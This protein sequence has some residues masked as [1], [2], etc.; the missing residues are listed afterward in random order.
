MIHVFTKG[1]LKPGDHVVVMWPS[2]QSFLTLSEH[3]GCK[4]TRWNLRVNRDSDSSSPVW[5]ADIDE[6]ETLIAKEGGARALYINAPHSPTGFQFTEQEYRRIVDI[7]K[8]HDTYLVSDECYS[9][10]EWGERG[11]LPPVCEIYDKGISLD[12]VSKALGLVSVNID[13]NPLEITV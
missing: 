2:Y 6:L 4:V 1:F 10:L 5:E 13:H 9:G 3:H 11:R 8:R 12:G 7:C